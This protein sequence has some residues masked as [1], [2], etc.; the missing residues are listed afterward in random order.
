MKLSMLEDLP[1]WR[2]VPKSYEELAAP[3]LSHQRSICFS[4][5][6]FAQLLTISREST[7]GQN[8]RG[9]MYQL[10]D[11]F[12]AL[13]VLKDEQYHELARRLDELT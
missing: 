8:N 10:D 3:L 11:Q 4:P 1:I 12:D 7:I 5:E 9:L 2:L 13:P 6:S